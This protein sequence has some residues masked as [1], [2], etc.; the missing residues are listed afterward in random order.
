MIYFPEYFW[1]YCIFSLP[2]VAPFFDTS[3]SAFLSSSP[4]P[5]LL[6]IPY[7]VNM[8]SCTSF[9]HFVILHSGQ[10][11]SNK[12][13]E[14]VLRPLDRI[15]RWCVAVPGHYVSSF[16]AS[17]HITHN[18]SVFLRHVRDV[19]RNSLSVPSV[20]FPVSFL[21]RLLWRVYFLSLCNFLRWCQCRPVY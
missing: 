2:I 4:S 7:S 12:I 14:D 16:V 15:F 17:T 18:A 1:S 8:C 6:Y 10:I 21:D 11:A 19:F 9:L 5:L 20:D 3:S 13:S